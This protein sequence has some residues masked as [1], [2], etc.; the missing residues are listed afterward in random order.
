M[1]DG[2]VADA[3]FEDPAGRPGMLYAVRAV[4]SS[5]NESGTSPAV[6]FEEAE[7]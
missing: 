4:D 5:G 6:V 2:L 7:P 1:T 3:R